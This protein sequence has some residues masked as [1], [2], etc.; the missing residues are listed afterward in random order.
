VNLLGL[1]VPI[2]LKSRRPGLHSFFLLAYALTWALL[3]P[4]FYV[5]NAI[6]HEKIPSWLWILAPLA[7][8]GGWGPS[9]AALIVTARAGRHG[10]VRRLMGSLA[11]WR[12]PAPWYVVTFL[13]PPLVTALSLLI[14]DAG[15]A[16]L[17]QFDVVRALAGVPVT[18]MLAL[19]FG[20][21]G[22]EL[23]WRG[24][25]LPRLLVRF[26]PVKASLLLGCV[27]TFWHL[28]MMLWSPGASIPSFMTLSMTSVAMYWVQITAITA[29]MTVLFLHTKGS[30]LLAVLAHLTF[31]TAEAVLFG[32]L[33][34]LAAGQQRAVYIVNVGLLAIL[35]LM[36]LCWLAARSKKPVAASREPGQ[37][38]S[39]QQKGVI[40]PECSRARQKRTRHN[41]SGRP[42]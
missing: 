8:I 32:G 37:Q 9:V 19:P 17:R 29:L 11:I 22:E 21:L 42:D 13:L 28:P 6:Y 31:N 27:W 38:T 20:P 3:G 5:F 12:V 24:F 40:S 15:L 7:F 35:G 18:Y 4:W 33:P 34:Q 26:G 23:G 10:A 30:V 14:V 36:S 2:D 1:E 41:N 39:G 25:A 16:H